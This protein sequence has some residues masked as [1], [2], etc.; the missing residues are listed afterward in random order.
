M[1]TERQP[2]KRIKSTIL[3]YPACVS[4]KIPLPVKQKIER[5]NEN[6]GALIEEIRQALIRKVEEHWQMNFPNEP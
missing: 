1:P 5:L 6:N 4:F 3:R 2:P